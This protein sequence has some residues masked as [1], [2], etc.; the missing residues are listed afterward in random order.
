MTKYVPP[1]DIDALLKLSLSIVGDLEE[2]ERKHL[3][4]SYNP[5][6]GYKSRYLAASQT[7][8]PRTLK[9]LQVGAEEGDERADVMR[10]ALIYGLS[11]NLEYKRD[12][13]ALGIINRK[14]A[15]DLAFPQSVRCRSEA[16]RGLVRTLLSGS[17]SK[18]RE[19][20]LYRSFFCSSMRE[21]RLLPLISNYIV[22]KMR[23]EPS[24]YSRHEISLTLIEICNV[25]FTCGTQ[26]GLQL[27]IYGGAE[28]T[29]I[30]PF[31][32]V[33]LSFVPSLIEL[34]VYG[35]DRY[36]KDDYGLITLPTI[37]LSI[38]L[39]V[40]TSKVARLA[41]HECSILSLSPLSL[42]DL[43]SLDTLEIGRD[44]PINGLISL[45]GLTRSNMKSLIS[46]RL[47]CPDLIDIS[48]LSDCDLSSLESLYFDDCSS[49]S[50]IS[51]L[52]GLDLSS[53]E[54]LSLSGTRVTDLS[55]LCEC[56]GFAPITMSPSFYLQDLTHFSMIDFSRW[57]D[58][59]S[60]LLLPSVLDLSPLE[61]IRY[62]GV[63]VSIRGPLVRTLKENST[64]FPFRIGKVEVVDGLYL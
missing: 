50:D 57:S 24:R 40:D 12:E 37:D 47:S 41:L 36:G 52:R 5:S 35:D 11:P 39:E 43:S 23:A 54:Y 53:L 25:F 17:L 1:L 30:S 48:A 7:T 8:I 62:V 32:P 34:E 61:N 55:P 42:C 14:T 15:N 33:L 27:C 64:T 28:G 6:P 4:L 44:I 26:V 31:L 18:N 20:A 58:T 3:L 45:E 13:F 56:R 51:P 29:F 10:K 19:S 9:W 21:T 16:T 59:N 22:P 60:P 49:L 46:L 63:R 2:W 38:L